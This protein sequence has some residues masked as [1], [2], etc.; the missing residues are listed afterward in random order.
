MRNPFIEKMR[1]IALHQ[2]KAAVEIFFRPAFN[3][4][5]PFGQ[6]PPTLLESTIHGFSITIPETLDD[7]EQHLRSPLLTT[8]LLA[9]LS[10]FLMNSVLASAYSFTSVHSRSANSFFNEAYFAAT[11]A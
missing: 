3:V 2:L 4:L 7:H 11:L 8:H 1:L 10:I 6:H 9:S 5:Q